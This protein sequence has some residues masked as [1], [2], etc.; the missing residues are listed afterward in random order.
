VRV[1]SLFPIPFSFSAHKLGILTWTNFINVTRAKETAE[2]CIEG[3]RSLEQQHR[4]ENLK[5]DIH[6][7]IIIED[8][9]MER[10]FGRLDGDKLH[11]YSYVWP[12]DSFDVTH[13]AFDVESV[14]EV[15]ARASDAILRIESS[16]LHSGRDGD[17]IVIVS[18]AD[19]L[20]ILQAYAAQLSNVGLFSQYRFGNGEVRALG[21]SP[22][23]LPPPS[24]LAVPKPGEYAP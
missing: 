8:G 1:A 5:I 7:E 22:D 12:V 21:R 14:A 20:Q 6:P 13:K 10:Y 11:T 16:G 17:I 2:A 23:T 24:P 15:S 19:T 9:F 18:H 3:L 4:L